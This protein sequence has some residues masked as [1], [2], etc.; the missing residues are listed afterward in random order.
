MSDL[1]IRR[2][3]TSNGGRYTVRIDG[4]AEEAELTYTVAAPGVVSANHTYSPDSMRGRGVALALVERLVADARAEGFKI[5]P[6]CSYVMA[7]ARRHPAWSD[8]L[9]DR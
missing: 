8:V 5:I 6:R 7:Q 4:I 2:E 9:A 1:D 3:T